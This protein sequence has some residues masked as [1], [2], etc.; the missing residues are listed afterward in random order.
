MTVVRL[1]PVS[2]HSGLGAAEPLARAC[3]ECG[4]G[5]CESGTGTEPRGLRR[6]PQFAR[7]MRVSACRKVRFR[8]SDN[9][10]SSRRSSLISWKSP[11][12]I[13]PPLSVVASTNHMSEVRLRHQSAGPVGANPTSSPAPNLGS[14]P[15]GYMRDWYARA[16]GSPSKSAAAEAAR[17]QPASRTN[18]EHRIQRP[19]YPCLFASN[20][21]N[22]KLRLR[23]HHGMLRFCCSRLAPMQ[24]LFLAND[25]MSPS[26]TNAAFLV[27]SKSESSPLVA[28]TPITTIAAITATPISFRR[29]SDTSALLTANSYDC[30][31]HTPTHG[32]GAP[33]IRFTCIDT[34]PQISRTSTMWA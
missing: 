14:R 25:L 1:G 10:I 12:H 23:V 2:R 22:R 7:R 18:R 20:T 32:G 5:E 8:K 28:T 21:N 17:A 15:C 19:S 24:C 33:G 4:G 3:G 13:S 6:C 29:F 27:L 11:S 9:R 34:D 16:T 26:L 30:R 31:R